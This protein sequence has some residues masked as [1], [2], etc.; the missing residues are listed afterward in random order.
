MTE[1]SL[2][3]ITMGKIITLITKDMFAI[4]MLILFGNDI[5][6]GLI[7]TVLICYLIYAKIGVSAFAG[8][9]FFLTVLPIQSI[10]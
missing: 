2:S 4:E 1:A 9:G 3:E 6:I 8:V 7:Q 10:D 5:W